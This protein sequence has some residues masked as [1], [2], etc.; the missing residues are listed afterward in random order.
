[1]PEAKLAAHSE[2]QRIRDDPSYILLQPYKSEENRSLIANY[3]RQQALAFCP[4][5]YVEKSGKGSV[6]FFYPTE[7]LCGYRN[8]LHGGFIASMLDE[9]L[10]FGIFGNFASR[11]GVT[12][13]LDVTY[14]APSLC[15]NL[16][17]VVCNTSKVEGRKGWISGELYRLTEGEEPILCAKGS[18]F[19]IEPAKLNLEKHL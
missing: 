4:Y 14:V 7:L 9:A 12:V 11:L 3:V 1:M 5:Y 2:F 10:A 15:S 8:I 19:F 16:Y 17:K 6:T 18:G 13:Q